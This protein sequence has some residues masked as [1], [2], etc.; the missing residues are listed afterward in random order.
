M[1]NLFARPSTNG[2]DEMSTVAAS[3]VGQ[4]TGTRRE[5]ALQLKDGSG[6]GRSGQLV[7]G[8]NSGSG[9]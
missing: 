9:G 2:A 4:Q 1:D 8:E 7:S 5:R 3:N 6:G